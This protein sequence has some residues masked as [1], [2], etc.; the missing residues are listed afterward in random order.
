MD[1]EERLRRWGADQQRR[2]AQDAPDPLATI[3]RDGQQRSCWTRARFLAPAAAAAAVTVIAV[4]VGVAHLAGRP[5]PTAT[6][7]A[8]A[9]RGEKTATAAPATVGCGTKAPPNASTA[10]YRATLVPDR[11]QSTWQ[12]TI[13]NNTSSAEV[14][15]RVVDLVAVDGEGTIIGAER[16][17]NALGSSAV[18]EPG[19]SWTAAVR[20]VA[21]DCR[22]SGRPPYPPIPAGT[23]QFLVVFYVGPHYLSSDRVLIDVTNDGSFSAH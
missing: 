13:T 5:H 18:L 9:V 22:A 14:L 15:N 12:L 17:P 19:R 6:P 7:A 11:G 3:R 20:P 16:T 21:E 23:Y 1:V 8:P 4:V 10:G 2:A